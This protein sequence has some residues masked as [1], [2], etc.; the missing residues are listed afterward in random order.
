MSGHAV[1][2]GVELGPGHDGHA[3]LVVELAY[4]N[5]GRARVSVPHQT[6]AHALDA[7]GIASIAELP[8]RP[9]TI[10]VPGVLATTDPAV[11]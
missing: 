3:E 7:A 4:P 10:L 6:A 8:G 5:G 9:W 2:V 1:I 11:S